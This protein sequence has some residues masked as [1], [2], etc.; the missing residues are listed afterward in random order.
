MKEEIGKRIEGI[1]KDLYMS[2]SKFAELIGVSSQYLGT[3]EKGMNGFSVEHIINICKKTGVSADYV[4]FGI[5]DPMKKFETSSLLSEFSQ[6]QI[7]IAFGMIE[8]M[9]L[10]LRTEDANELLIRS[11]CQMSQVG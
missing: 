1:R 11:I 10:L 7:H 8:K 9:A 4:L 2:K 3:V 6:E 5:H